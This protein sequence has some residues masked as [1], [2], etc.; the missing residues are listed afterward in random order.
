MTNEC[1]CIETLEYPVTFKNGI[2]HIRVECC[3][4][5]KF[6]KWKAKP[7]DEFTMWFGKYKGEK[8]KDIPD[9]YLSWYVKN[10]SNEKLVKKLK[11]YL[12]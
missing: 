5:G 7:L 10:G 1:L 9:D 3:D 8:L 12:N 11:S 2:T 6:I 4:C